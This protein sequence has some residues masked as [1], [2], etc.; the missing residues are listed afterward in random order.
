MCPIS[1]LK[2]GRYEGA[3]SAPR[4]AMDMLMDNQR[5]QLDNSFFIF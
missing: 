5:E 2:V 4:Y 1:T 3:L